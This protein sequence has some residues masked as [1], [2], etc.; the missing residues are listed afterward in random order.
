MYYALIN[1]E[2]TIK[3]KRGIICYQKKQNIDNFLRI[4]DL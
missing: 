2:L 3:Q 4:G 1:S